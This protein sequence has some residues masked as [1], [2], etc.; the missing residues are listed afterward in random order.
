MFDAGKKVLSFA[1]IL[2][3]LPGVILHAQQKD[4][5]AKAGSVSIT[6]EEFV[7]RFELSPHPRPDKDYDSVK[8]K[9]DFIKTII[10]EKQIGRAHV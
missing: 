5:L 8:I 1:F 7:K 2:G 6:K 9:K 3:F 4:V 10:A